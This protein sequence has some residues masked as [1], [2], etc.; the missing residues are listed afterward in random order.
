MATGRRMENSACLVHMPNISNEITLLPMTRK[1]YITMNNSTETWIELST[2]PHT[3][4]A[5]NIIKY[6]VI[7]YDQLSESDHLY[8]HQECMQRYTDRQKILRAHRQHEK[9]NYYSIA[10]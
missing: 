7:P 10:C 9:V 4:I 2:Q 1:R 3:D 6:T 8:F 5:S